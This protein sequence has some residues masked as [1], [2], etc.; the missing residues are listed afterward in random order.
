MSSVSSVSPV[1]QSVCKLTYANKT[2]QKIVITILYHINDKNLQ[3]STDFSQLYFKK[4]VFLKNIILAANTSSSPK[5][6]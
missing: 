4:I 5:Q 2:D 3:I 6:K 1:S